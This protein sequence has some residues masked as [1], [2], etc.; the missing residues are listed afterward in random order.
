MT[1]P[2]PVPVATAASS[3]LAGFVRAGLVD[4]ELAGLLSLTVEARIPAVVIGGPAVVRCAVRDALLGQLPAGTRIV[5]LAGPSETFA[6]MPERAALGWLPSDIGGSE[7]AG[8]AGASGSTMVAD[9]EQGGNGTWGDA[10]RLAIRALTAGYDLVAT[11]A[12]SSLED[13]L[14]RLAAA[15]VLAIDDELTRLGVVLVLGG[16][17]D[18]TVRVEAAHYLRPAARD[19]GGHVQRLPPAVLATWNPTTSRFDHFAWGVV[20]EIAWRAGRR[21]LELEREQARRAAAFAAAGTR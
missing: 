9:L 5:V 20:D 16:D 21:P 15:P 12:G 4:A 18:G 1:D 13:L 11:A 14:S 7:A 6:W 2:V 17:P 10:A 3:T 19:A 8:S